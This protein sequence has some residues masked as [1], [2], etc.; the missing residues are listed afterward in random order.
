MATAMDWMPSTANGNSSR[1][2]EQGIILR[3]G[4]KVTED[5]LRRR[6]YEFGAK[7]PMQ[8]AEKDVFVDGMVVFT[9]SFVPRGSVDTMAPVFGTFAGKC[10]KEAVRVAGILN[11]SGDKE[12]G[13]DASF[14][15]RGLVP[16]VKY[17]QLEFYDGDRVFWGPPLLG[18]RGDGVVVGMGFLNGQEGVPEDAILPSMYVHRHGDASSRFCEMKERIDDLVRDIFASADWDPATGFD[19]NVNPY[20]L[21]PDAAAAPYLVNGSWS[22]DVSDGGAAPDPVYLRDIQAFRD[23]TGGEATAM[24]FTR[25][26]FSPR[27]AGGAGGAGAPNDDRINAFL[28]RVRLVAEGF[29]AV[30]AGMWNPLTRLAYLLAANYGVYNNKWGITPADG[31]APPGA[32]PIERRQIE[33]AIAAAWDFQ[34]ADSFVD[35]K[36]NEDDR[37]IKATKMKY[38]NPL[39]SGMYFSYLAIL[40]QEE[41]ARME[42]HFIGTNMGYSGVN[43][44]EWDCLLGPTSF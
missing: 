17:S 19:A 42:T 13:N 24:M 14:A 4:Q 8:D 29:D 36:F 6:A 35:R 1:V 38:T 21:L 33:A 22:P 10:A 37:V 27:G 39:D 7:L 34:L 40:L 12:T 16:S 30:E 32:T 18:D 31:D 23:G 43:R 3:G 44:L 25:R 41:R 26:Y 5:V 9:S 20:M 15:V 28:S 2:A 11:Q